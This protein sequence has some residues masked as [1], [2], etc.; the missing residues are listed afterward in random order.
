MP[1]V[2]VRSSPMGAFTCL[3][4]LLALGL[5]GC[6]PSPKVEAIASSTAAAA[7]AG[8][9]ESAALGADRVPTLSIDGSD[10]T[11]QI[12]YTGELDLEVDV[13]VFN[14]DLI[15]TPPAAIEAL[16]RKGVYVICYF[17]AGSWEDWRPDAEAFPGEVL[18]QSLKGWPGERWLDISLLDL[19]T[20]I[21]EGRLDL[22]VDKGC[23]GVDP[24]NVDGYQ[25]ETGFALQAQDQLAYN[26]FLSEAAHR[27][28]LAIGLKNDLDQIPDLLPYFDW[29]LNEE[30]F[31]YG[32]CAQLV[33][34]RESGK[35]VFIIEYVLPPEAFCPEANRVGF[36]AIR[37]NLELDAYRVDCHSIS[38]GF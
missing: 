12:Q 22:A 18:G 9:N 20:P 1:N 16:H 24:D 3:C 4:L 17:S 33:P 32:E 13:D 26:I 38:A 34:F 23:D 21:M 31:S 14:L 6:A 27:R 19:L 11:W 28:G 8:G 7:A 15:E 10:L 30:C 25:N 29:V 5:S 35:P 36:N 37:K 2:N